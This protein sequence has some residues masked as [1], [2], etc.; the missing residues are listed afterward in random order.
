MLIKLH[1]SAASFYV[2]FTILVWGVGDQVHFY[3]AVLA[4]QASYSKTQTPGSTALI[5]KLLINFC[6]AL[7][8]L[9]KWIVAQL[10][11]SSSYWM[12]PYLGGTRG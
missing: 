9:L 8:I 6:P 4:N 3:T 10:Q 1:I 7:T 11:L 5:C 12:F 2:V